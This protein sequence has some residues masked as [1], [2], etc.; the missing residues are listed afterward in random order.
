MQNSIGHRVEL[1]IF[2]YRHLFFTIDSQLDCK[3]I[4]S[5]NQFTNG[6]LSHSEIGND[7]TFFTTGKFYQFFTG[8]ERSLI[9][10]FYQLATIQHCGNQSLLTQTFYC[11][12]AQIGTGRTIQL[13]CFHRCVVLCYSKLSFHC[14]LISHHTEFSKSGAKLTFYFLT[15]KPLRNYS[16]RNKNR[17]SVFSPHSFRYLCHYEDRCGSA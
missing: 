11:F 4:G 9:R 5:I 6:I 16:S 1:Q 13:K 3:N 15:H 12:L 7:N 17:G 2:Q 14:S 8:F 10:Q